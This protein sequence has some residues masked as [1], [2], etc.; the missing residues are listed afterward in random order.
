MDA[1]VKRDG[2]KV[3]ISLTGN[4]FLYN[5]VRIITGTL[6][7]VGLNKIE[8]KDMKAILEAKDRTKAGKTISP[9]GLYLVSVEY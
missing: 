7:D 5:M 4:G 8:P 3:I 2:D 6:I 9:C 1:Y